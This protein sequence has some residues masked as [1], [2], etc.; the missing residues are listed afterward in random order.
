MGNLD[1]A[2]LTGFWTKL[3]GRLDAKADKGEIPGRNLLDNSDFR[4]PVNQRGKASY[5]GATVYSIDRW[6]LYSP[7]GTASLSVESGGIAINLQTESV[8]TVS[9]RLENIDTA[10]AYT[11]ATMDYTGS[12]V[13]DN[14]PIKLYGETPYVEIL[15]SAWNRIVWA[16]LYEGTYTADT[17]PTYAPKDYASELLK[18]QR[19]YRIGTKCLATQLS[20]GT[21]GA[22]TNVPYPTP[23]RISPTVIITDIRTW[24]SQAPLAITASANVRDAG[25]FNSINLSAAIDA[26][27]YPIQFAYS[28]SADL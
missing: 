18:C 13:V 2:G 25:G 17:L 10:K 23:M 3:K 7:G 24:A 20:T 9:Q 1:Y 8:A 12:I 22:L 28:A 14:H 16:A 6:I 21:A 11:F 19:Y 5:T 15:L 4:N 27:Q 26:Y